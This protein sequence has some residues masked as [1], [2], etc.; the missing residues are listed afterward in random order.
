MRQ[1]RR[2]R[3]QCCSHRH[4]CRMGLLKCSRHAS[5]TR[6][7]DRQ[8]WMGY[9]KVLQPADRP[10]SQKDCRFRVCQVLGGLGERTAV[11]DVKPIDTSRC[12]R[13]RASCKG[14]RINA[15]PVHWHYTYY[16]YRQAAMEAHTEILVQIDEHNH[17]AVEAMNSGKIWAPNVEDAAKSWMATPRFAKLSAQPWP[18]ESAR[19]TTNRKLAVQTPI[20]GQ[21]GQEQEHR[22][23]GQSRRTRISQFCRS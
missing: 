4:H 21:A 16:K 19:Y 12:F 18:Q 11:R 2:R 23:R 3:C 10:A 8:C 9:P 22:Q 15:C 14:T 17:A 7:L 20:Q 13:V 5:Q 1:I 6:M